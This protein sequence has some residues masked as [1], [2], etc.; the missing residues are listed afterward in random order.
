MRARRASFNILA[1]ILMGAAFAAFVQLVNDER[2]TE[3]NYGLAFVAD[4]YLLS[5]LQD[6]VSP[7]DRTPKTVDLSGKK[8]KGYRGIW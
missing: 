7:I 6:P 3:G 1:F 8:A 4:R 5:E 2:K